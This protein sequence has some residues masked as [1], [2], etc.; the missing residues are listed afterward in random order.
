MKKEFGINI[1]LKGGNYIQYF[2]FEEKLEAHT[3]GILN[4]IQMARAGDHRTG[5]IVTSEEEMK[6][7]IVC[8]A[9]GDEI[10][11]FGVFLK[12]ENYG[13][14]AL[15]G[16]PTETEALMMKD[17][18]RLQTESLKLTIELQKRHLK[19]LDEGETWRDS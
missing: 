4:T 5:W 17:L 7:H 9:M 6:G 10:E 8:M 19:T 12:G 16:D 2:V 1:A 14:G 15:R 18:M 13:P 3:R 11:G